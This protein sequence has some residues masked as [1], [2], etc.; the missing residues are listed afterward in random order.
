MSDLAVIVG[1]TGSVG[2]VLC[3]RLVDRGMDVVAVA[4]SGDA[5]AELAATSARIR[6]VA[7][8][9]A[10][11]SSMA[12]ITS[13]VDRQVRLAVIAVGLPVRGSV[14]TIDPDALAVGA[15]VKLGGTTRLLRALSGHLGPGSVFAAFAGTLGLE[16]R[17]HEA[18]PGAVNAGL[19]NLMKQISLLYGPRGVRVHTVVPGPADTPR[20]RHIVQTVAE[21]Q[22]RGFDEVWAE[23]ER[24]NS[25]GRFPEVEEVAWAVEML[26]ADE[27]AIM[28]GTVLHLDAGGLRGI[29]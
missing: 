11:N 5:L 27:A 14:D 25:L 20:L 2:S 17:A 15:N 7:A 21:E 26:L 16:P 24:Q 23:Y 28:H 19:I 9:I 18:G 8:D 13:A 3:R 22:G 12:A 29:T 6:V 1:A 10:D 4:R